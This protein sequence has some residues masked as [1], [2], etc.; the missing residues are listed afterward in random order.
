MPSVEIR[1]VGTHAEARAF[2]ELP[3]SLH[4]GDPLWV[5]P[6]RLAERQKWE[7]R[8]NASLGRLGVV[9]FLAWRGRRAVGRIAAMSDPLFQRWAPG[10][11]FFGFFE[12]EDDPEVGSALLG[13]AEGDLLGRGLIS[14]LGPV[15]HTTHEE[16]GF[17]VEGFDRP[18][19]VLSPHNPPY[20]GALAEQ[21]GYQGVRDY[22]AFEW[23]PATVPHRP[24]Q[25]LARSLEAARGPFR[26]VEIRPLDPR[27]WEQDLRR[28]HGLYNTCFREVWG[29]VEISWEEFRE[30]AE[31]FRAFYRP[32]LAVLAEQA[33]EAVGFALIL[34]DVNTVLARLGG[35]LLPLGWLRA[36]RQIPLIRTGRFILI[37]VRPDQEG[38]ALAPALTLALREALLE[39]GFGTVEISLV[40][41]ANRKMLRVVEGWRC[42]PTKVFRLYGRPLY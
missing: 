15:N 32:E 6:L 2:L 3:Y 24:I 33:G 17:L 36:R 18:P 11:G 10:S 13:A 16:V 38:R 35:R 12:S 37:G 14:V 34:P 9:R 26:G 20:Y 21:A 7:T 30:R 29:F 31:A 28:V 27:R 41:E 39:A 4:R 19:T 1:Q 8:K 25:R 40:Q 42:R 23:T 22:L 5:P